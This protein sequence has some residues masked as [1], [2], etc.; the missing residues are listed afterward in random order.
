MLTAGFP[1]QPFSSL[2]EQPGLD[3]EKG[4][5]FRQIV[6][7]LEL[8]RPAAFLLENVPGL[9]KVDGKAPSRSPAA[10]GPARR[11]DCC[12]A[13]FAAMASSLGRSST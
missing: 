8:R 5:L 9:L 10:H 1:C 12:D 4:T 11:S 13:R 2:G 7:V 6:R 3:D